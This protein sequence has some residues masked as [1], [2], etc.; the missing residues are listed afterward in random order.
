[1]VTTS[2]GAWLRMIAVVSLGCR[3]LPVDRDDHVTGLDAGRRRR[4]VL[5]DGGDADAAGSLALA[6]DGVDGEQQDD[7]D[8]ASASATRP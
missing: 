5:D 6:V 7:G 1:M 3:D 2:P 8:R 4:V